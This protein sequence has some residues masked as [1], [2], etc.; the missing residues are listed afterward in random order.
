[1]KQLLLLRHA[2][3]QPASPHIKDFDRILTE[4]GRQE[5]AQAADALAAARLTIDEIL[6]SPSRRTRETAD[7]VM[8][9]LGLRMPAR[10]VAELYLAAP[11]VMLETLEGC[12][13]T[14]ST[15]LLIAHNPGIS[16]L[17]RQLGGGSGGLSLRTAGLCHLSLAQDRWDDIGSERAS[18]WQLLR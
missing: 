3:A 17:A 2:E 16:E 5:A 4:R 10:A 13:V 7:S 6:V 9:R 14:S 8:H 18:A 1:V 12:Q 15:V 11:G